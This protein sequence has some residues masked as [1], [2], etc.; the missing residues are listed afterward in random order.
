GD[1]NPALSYTVG[2]LGLVNGDML[3]GSLVITAGQYSN[4]GTYAISQGSLANANYAITYDGAD[5]TINKRAITVAANNQSRIYGDANPALSFTVGG[6]GLVNNDTLSGLLATSAT[7]TSNAGTYAI[8]QGTLA[9]TGN[10]D[11]SFTGADLTVSKRAITV[12]AN[13]QS[14]IY[15]DANPTL[16]YTVGGAGLV[17]NDSLTGGLA[18]AAN[19]TADI[20]TYAISQGTLAATGNYDLSFTGAD[21][22]VSKRAITVAANNQSRIYGDA[23][24]TLSYTVGGAGLV[25]NDRLTGGLTTLATA[26]SGVGTNAILQGS[27]AASGNY[28]LTFVGGNLRITPRALTVA[29]NHASRIYGDANPVFSYAVSG[30]INGDT[31]TGSL[32][33]S[34]TTSSGIGTYTIGLGTLGNGNYAISYSGNSLTVTPRGIAVTAN[35]A[36]RFSGVA[37]PTFTYTVGDAGLVN[38]DRLSGALATSADQYSGPGRY[39][40]GQGSLAASDNYRLSFV[41]GVLTV[42]TTSPTMELASVNTPRSFAPDMLPLPPVGEQGRTPTFESDGTGKGPQTYLADPRFDGMVLCFDNGAACV[43]RLPQ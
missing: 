42:I 37:N 18:T 17:N 41:G 25:N 7:D 20:G 13:N 34:A 38:G 35:N 10:Y 2:G 3:S 21:L 9:A 6:A 15:G 26:A 19:A 4:V 24:P 23:N 12:A 27:L 40:I 1:A 31:L 16:S 29:A 22:T 8:S 43:A 36:S 30:L 11:L 33:S 28:D 14:R 5:L 32:A 39:A